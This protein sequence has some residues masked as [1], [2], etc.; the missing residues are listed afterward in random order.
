MSLSA[1]VLMPFAKTFDKRYGVIKLAVRGAEMRCTRAD[2]QSFHRQ[3]ITERITQQIDDADVL[4]ADL[5]TNNPNVLFEVGYAYAK[6]KLCILLTK[7]AKAIPFDLKN[8][9]HIIFSGLDDL[10]AK[11]TNDLKALNSEAELSFDRGD[12][13]CVATVPISVITTTI[14]G[15]S[16]ATS[17]RAKVTTGSEIHQKN[18][19]AQM[20]RVERR[21]EKKWRRF[22]LEQPISLTWTDTDTIFTDFLGPVTRYVNVF[23]IDHK[24]GKLTVW[25]MSMP[26]TLAEFLSPHGSYRVTISTMG[27]QLQL[28]ILWHGDWNTMVVKR[29]K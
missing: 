9:R 25:K 11:L 28:I 27:R 23:H 19:A 18:V 26:A 14:V 2:K 12:S 22:K 16:Q 4:I 3:G 20:V 21:L 13:E 6:N 17:I 24:E 10:R 5:S 7:D 1:F 15:T 8:R 29:A